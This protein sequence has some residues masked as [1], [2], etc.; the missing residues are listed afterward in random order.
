MKKMILI[1]FLFYT[2]AQAQIFKQDCQI[3]ADG[4]ILQM[5]LHIQDSKL[6]Y[7]ATAFEEENCLK[8][9]LIF[10][11]EYSIL[12]K[13]SD[14]MQTKHLMASYT[15]LSNEVS[16]ALNMII[17]CGI[18][19]WENTNKTDVTGAYCDPFQQA[20]KNQPILFQ[21]I[22]NGDTLYFNNEQLP[23]KKL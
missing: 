21:F 14:S 9:Y 15:P 5:I 16:E 17:Y 19:T 1:I 20:H 3:T 13:N 8:P 4:D 22:D 23:Y 12:Q 11:R 7:T 18:M 2:S 6:V 10:E